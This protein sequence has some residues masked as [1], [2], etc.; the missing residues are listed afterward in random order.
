MQF[1]TIKSYLET[2]P[3]ENLVSQSK[4]G[5]NLN[6]FRFLRSSR[7]VLASD[8]DLHHCT[9]LHVIP[10]VFSFDSATTTII[11]STVDSTFSNVPNSCFE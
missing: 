7:S 3:E 11:P 1:K 6:V 5:S 2:L 10:V 9:E 4:T 8:I